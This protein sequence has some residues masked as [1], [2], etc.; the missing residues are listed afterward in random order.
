MYANVRPAKSVAGYETPYKDVHIVLIRENTEGEY[1][2]IEHRI[3]PGVFVSV[4]VITREAST[5]VCRFAFE[6][7]IE[8]QRPRVIVVHHASMM[9]STDGLFVASAEDVAKAFP[10]IRMECLELELA[11]QQVRAWPTSAL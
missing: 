8:I 9:P 5:K 7:A 6:H 1:S 2:G 4:K 10:S 11:C 3:A